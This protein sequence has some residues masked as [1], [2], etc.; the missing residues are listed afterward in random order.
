MPSGNAGGTRCTSRIARC[1]ATCATR[2][3]T[4][5]GSGSSTAPT[6]SSAFRALF[7]DERADYDAA[8]QRA[9][10]ERRAGRLAGALRHRLRQR[11]SVGGLGRDLGALPAHDRHARDGGGVRRVDQAAAPRRAGA[12]A[13]AADRGRRRD[14]AFDRLIASWF[15]L[16][17]VLNNLNRGLGARRRLSVRALAAGGRE[18]ALR[19]RGHRGSAARRAAP[20]AESDAAARS[21][22][23]PAPMSACR[24]KRRGRPGRRYDRAVIDWLLIVLPGV[25][26]GASFL[27]IAEGLTA[28]P[29]DGVTFLRIPSASSPSA[30]CRGRASRL[31]GV[32]GRASPRSA[33]CGSRSR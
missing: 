23:L 2:S 26:W 15:P 12:G 25:I 21:P 4:T 30:W 10:P 6:G 22:P 7:G 5:T 20:P 18:A 19:A 1:S 27:F 29:P 33:C 17:Y 28:V 24:T 9:L 32:T 16:T 31:C 11:A 3:A 14:A 8:L 13:R